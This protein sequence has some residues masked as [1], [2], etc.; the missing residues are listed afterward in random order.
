[1]AIEESRSF[2]KYGMD[3]IPKPFAEELQILDDAMGNI[4]H[5][6]TQSQHFLQTPPNTARCNF[7]LANYWRLIDFTVHC[8]L[9]SERIIVK[10]NNDL[11]DNKCIK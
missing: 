6:F 11:F 8:I 10:Q 2:N 9:E 5:N 3:A 7:N 1:L 4:L